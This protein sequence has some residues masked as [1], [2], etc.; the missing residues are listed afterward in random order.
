MSGLLTEMAQTSLSRLAQARAKES[1]Q[2]L[3]ARASDAPAAPTLRL[4]PEGFDILAE[5]KLHSP[6]G[7]DLSANTAGVEDRVL[8]YGQGGACA[9]SVLTEPTRF[10]GTLE[11]LAQKF[12]WVSTA[13]TS[14]R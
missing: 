2:S 1:E 10:G 13:G 11:H 14:K 7:G 12:S 4:S 6:S 8:A 9:V 3:W 5:C